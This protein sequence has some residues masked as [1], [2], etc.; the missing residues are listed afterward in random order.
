MR[1]LYT[2]KRDYN[3][4]FRI[5]SNGKIS[6]IVST[7]LLGTTLLHSAPSGGVVTSGSAAITQNGAIT[8]I[9]QSTQKASI[10]WSTFS[11]GSSETVNF[12]QPNTSSITLNRIVGN[13]KSVIDGTLNANG[14]VWILNSNGVLFGKNASVNTSGLLASTKALSDADFQAGIYTLSGDSKASIIN[15]GT[16][17]IANN[18]YAALLANTVSNE[19]TIKAIKGTIELVGADAFNINLNGNSLVNLTVTKGVLDALVENKGALIA[20]GGEIYLTTNA[21]NDL[22]KGVVN[23]TGVIE[24]QTLDDVTG[25]IEL[26]AHGGEVRVGGSITT[27]IGEGFVETSGKTFS[28]DPSASIITGE[29]LLDPVNITIDTTLA[30]AIMTALGSGNVIISTDGGNT[31]NTTSGESGSAG[32]INVNSAITWATNRTL[33]LLAFNDIN[34]NANLT[35]TGTSA[36]GMIFFYGQGTSDGGSSKYTLNSGATVT[37]PS[38]Q[39]RKGSDL[40]STRYAIVNGDVFLGNKYIEIGINSS[41]GGKFGTTSKPSLFFGRQGGLSGI[42]MTGDADGFGTGADLRIDYFLP[43]SPYEAFSAKYDIS[44]IV[45]TATNF[46]TLANSGKIELLPLGADNI[47]TAKVTTTL[48][49]NLKVEQLITLGVEKKYF[50][51]QVTLTNVGSSTLNNVAF[52]RSFD[53]DNTVDIGGSYVTTQKIEQRV[54]E[55]DTATVVSATSQAGDAYSTR[56]GGAQSKIIYYSTDERSNV[57]F[58]SAFFGGTITDMLTTAAAQA[59]GAT[60]TGDIGLGIIL[61]AGTLAT[62]NSATFNYFTSLDNRDMSVILSELEAAAK[63][64]KI[65]TPTTPSVISA[66]VNNTAVEQPRVVQ[67]PVGPQ[68]RDR[69][70]QTPTYEHGGESITLASTAGDENANTLVSLSEIRQMQRASGTPSGTTE[71][72][73]SEETTGA[74]TSV[75]VP[76]SRGSLIDI[77]NGGVKL[78]ENVE[79]EFYV[80]NQTQR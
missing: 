32:D 18:G 51:N 48:S 44:G 54:S 69:H 52:V 73:T 12:N 28:I 7:L 71:Q 66:I 21:V 75:R 4:Y 47:L 35:H 53:P 46:V 26:Y 14:Q 13:E 38:L 24:A 59:K 16:I 41:A 23:N 1:N 74:D 25:K 64:I 11:I 55:G 58:G 2:P 63:P 20:N 57:G 37:S 8:N 50:D 76:L 65:P 34:I 31:P 80:L 42:G 62:G 6:L 72:G 33:T 27:G 30:N 67:Q 40:S 49:N 68:Q 36:G 70:T 19:G 43:G 45:T 15:L 79:Q 9:N 10:N 56:A 22:L 60:A 5:P 39:W 17:E 29:W 78:P 3:S 61:S 77:V